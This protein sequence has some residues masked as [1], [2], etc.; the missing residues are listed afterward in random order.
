MKNLTIALILAL[1]TSV[2]SIASEDQKGNSEFCSEKRKSA[3]VAKVVSKEED[4]KEKE[5]STKTK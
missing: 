1:S 2:A 3:A 4:K 5:A